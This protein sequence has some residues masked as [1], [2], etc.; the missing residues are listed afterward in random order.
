MHAHM[1]WTAIGGLLVG[2]LGGFAVP[3]RT[4]LRWPVSLLLGL[5]GAFG[6]SALALTVLGT[7][8]ETINLVVA[9]VIAALP[10]FAF[11]VYERT[12]VLP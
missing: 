12:R 6:G 10:V 4:Q 2:A 3:D 11:T 5:S 9:V 1:L 7:A 8:H